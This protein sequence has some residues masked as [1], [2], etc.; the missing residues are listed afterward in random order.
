MRDEEP[1]PEFQI[2]Q[3]KSKQLHGM[4]VSFSNI[5]L[6]DEENEQEKEQDEARHS[7]DD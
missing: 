1:I 2:L 5:N 3:D 7:D 6:N 4:D